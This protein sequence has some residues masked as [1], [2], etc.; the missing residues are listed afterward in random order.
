VRDHIRRLHYSIRTETAYLGWIKRYILFHGKRHPQEMG[1]R[2]IEAFL[3]HLAVH[4]QVAASTQNQALNALVF[5]YRKVL[6]RE[7]AKD[8]NIR[9]AKRPQRL[10]TFFERDDLGRMFQ[11]LQGTQGLI[12]RLLYGS[13]MRLLECLRLRVQD[14]HFERK[15]ITVRNGKGQKDRVTLLPAELIPALQRQLSLAKAAH[16]AD[17]AE[18]YGEVYLPY[19]LERKYPNADKEWGWQYVFFASKR[20]RDP[21]SGKTRR[22]HLDQ[23][24]ANKA[25]KQA[26]R[27]AGIHKLG[28]CHSLRHNAASLIMPNWSVER[29]SAHGTASSAPQ[30]AIA[31]SA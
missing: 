7:L 9:H 29:A 13:G 24:V 26:K 28:S 10:P 15:A 23:S 25:L 27:E 19:A 4:G 30:S 21:R 1:E 31:Y 2:E 22:H 18:G 5:C 16:Q 14:L 17:L 12:L 6:G 11:S 20:A 8:M 3:N